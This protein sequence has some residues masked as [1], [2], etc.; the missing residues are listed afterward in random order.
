L[1]I[2]QPMKEQMSLPELVLAYSLNSSRTLRFI[3]VKRNAL[4]FNRLK[5][6][7]VQ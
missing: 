7:W 5:T 2:R 1:D 6:Q 4:F 3:M